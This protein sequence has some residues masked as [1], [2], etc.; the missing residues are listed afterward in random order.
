MRL[1]DLILPVVIGG[2]LFYG[3]IKKV[4]IY[5]AFI[6]GAMEGAKAALKIFPYILA[7]IFAINMFIHSGAEDFIVR[8]LTPITNL[9]GFPP[10]LLSLSIVK[11]LSGGG[12]LGVFQSILDNYGPDSYIGRS[13]SVLMGSSETIFYT[14]AVYFGAVGIKNIRHTIKVGLIAHVGSIF[15]AL[16][17]CRFFM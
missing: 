11:P 2:I 16:M 6:D 7:V 3:I 17:V 10:E 13:A 12:S 4:D 14:T 15:A 1:S 9:L 5:A 8:I